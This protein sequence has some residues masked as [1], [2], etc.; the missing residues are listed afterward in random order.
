MSTLTENPLGLP[1]VAVPAKTRQQ[2]AE[3]VAAGRFALAKAVPYFRPVMNALTMIEAPGLSEALA[4]QGTSAGI[5]V[6]AGG[7]CYFDPE[8]MAKLSVKQVAADI[9]HEM[10]HLWNRHNERRGSRDPA[11][12]N[13]AADRSINPSVIEVG[14]DFFGGC[15][16]PKDI[17]MQN[18]LAA[19]SYYKP[20][21]DDQQPRRCGSC[22][23]N[24]LPGEPP[25]D[26]KKEQG[27][28]T[29]AEMKRAFRS[30]AEGIRDAASKNQGRIPADW[31][32]MADATLEPAIVPWDQELAQAARV[33]TGWRAGAVDHRYDA[34]SRRQAGIGYGVGK[35][36]L[37]RLRQPIPEV[38][39]IF[40]T[41]GSMGR[42]ET[43]QSL[44]EADGVI[45]TLGA[46]V[47]IC[48]CD[49]KVHGVG[50]VASIR[51]VLPMLK[52]GGGTDFIPAFEA[53][54]AAKKRPDLIVFATD[55]YGSAPA[56]D[57]GINTIW[58][59]VG[60]NVNENCAAWG[61]KIRV[62]FEGRKR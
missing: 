25:P 37:P 13:S 35:P 9:L 38:W 41:S 33:A 53:A 18:G 15:L 4:K 1:P 50:K 22:S 45:K 16:L 12:W 8:Y 5:G 23:G 58:L 56:V 14:F 52:G 32:K 30:V 3:N 39:F 31:K 2:A 60:P 20:E 47:T 49:A 6:T 11:K 48:V 57:P 62:P 10:L 61:K 42:E 19:E 7:L 36:I 21:Q 40:D 24:A 26:Q 55:G 54:L 46:E 17:G 29:E 28:R 34:P 59:F 43:K 27:E 44:V 51:E